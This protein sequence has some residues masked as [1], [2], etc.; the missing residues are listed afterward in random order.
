MDRGGHTEH[1]REQDLPDGALPQA[2]HCRRHLLLCLAHQVLFRL[3]R[4]FQLANKQYINVRFGEA[5]F[6]DLYIIISVGTD[7][8]LEQAIWQ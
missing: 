6:R 4:F 5:S 3:E 8:G 1:L 7:Q 2:L